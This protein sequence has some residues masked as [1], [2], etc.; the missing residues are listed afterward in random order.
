MSQ[1][2]RPVS[3][4]SSQAGLCENSV[5]LIHKHFENGTEFE[6]DLSCTILGHTKSCVNTRESG[7]H[8]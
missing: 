1:D 2:G 3:R 8:Y 7:A 6:T 5:Y 4:G